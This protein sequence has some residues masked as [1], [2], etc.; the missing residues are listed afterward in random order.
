MLVDEL[1]N[2]GKKRRCWR[3]AFTFQEHDELTD[4]ILLVSVSANRWDQGCFRQP[5]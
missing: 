1:I 5:G 2:G 4:S 3:L